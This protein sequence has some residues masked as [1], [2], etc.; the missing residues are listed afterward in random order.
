MFHFFLLLLPFVLARWLLLFSQGGG[1]EA[2]VPTAAPTLVSLIGAVLSLVFL[3]L[4]IRNR[5]LY[6]VS[7]DNLK[8][9][10]GFLYRPDYAPLLY[11]TQ[12]GDQL[13]FHGII[14]EEE[15]RYSSGWNNLVKHKVLMP[16]FYVL[17]LLV[18]LSLCFSHCACM[19]NGYERQNQDRVFD[20]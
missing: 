5:Q 1:G 10:E 6:R 13:R 14:T 4:D 12:L 15:S 2:K 18:Y 20:N 7:Q 8:F 19:S 16:L 17:A 11:K 9:I 3:F